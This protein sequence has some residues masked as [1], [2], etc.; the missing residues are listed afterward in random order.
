MTGG[1]RGSGRRCCSRRCR[2]S[3]R[4]AWWRWRTAVGTCPPQPGRR[5]SGSSRQ[6]L[7]SAPAPAAS[8]PAVRRRREA[9]LP[10]PR[11]RG[12]PWSG[13]G[14]PSASDGPNT[15][16][17]CRHADRPRPAGKSCWRRVW[18]CRVRRSAAGEGLGG[19]PA[20]ASAQP[21]PDSAHN[22]RIKTLVGCRVFFR[23]LLP[24]LPIRRADPW[25]PVTGRT[26][27]RER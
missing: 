11:E 16:N 12:R 19:R 23:H 9:A 21:R 15:R 27:A 26:R 4:C 3:W 6:G 5:G 7:P 18:E 24:H 17:P 13:Q 20:P 10:P 22:S 8:L 14:V 1:R 2:W 25:S